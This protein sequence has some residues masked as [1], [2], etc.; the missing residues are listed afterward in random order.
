MKLTADKKNINK[1]LAVI[2][3]GA[4]QVIPGVLN[5]AVSV[6]VVRLFSAAWWGEIIE[7]Q[8]VYYI[9]GSVVSWGNKEYFLREFSKGPARINEL[10]GKGFSTRALYLLLPCCIV[11]FFL[12]KPFIFFNLFIWVSS[13]FIVQSYE[14]VSTYEKKFMPLVA[15][16]V[17]AFLVMILAFIL[18][19]ETLTY[20]NLVLVFS[21]G[22]LVKVPVVFFSFRNYSLFGKTDVK[23]LK[24]ASLFFVLAFTGFVSTKID[25]AIVDMLMPKEDLGF[26]QVITNFFIL[27]R[28][29]S[30]FIL[31]PFVKNIYRFSVAAIEKSARHLLMAGLGICIAGLAAQFVFIKIFY[32]FEVPLLW[33]LY[34]FVYTLPGFWFSPFVFYFFGE[35]KQHLVIYGN[36]LCMIANAALCFALIPA[37]GISGALIAIA[38]PQ[39]MLMLYFRYW[40]R[41]VS[42][43]VS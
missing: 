2:S 33:Y 42:A 6:L 26:Y 34:G 3:N 30:S 35:H 24:E 8:L 9:V 39:I 40:F 11:L 22:Y 10:F 14:S 19:P 43:G 1:L 31:Y 7:L 21:L 15:A 37:Y 13:R 17:A 28:T 32:L 29:V 36:V 12:Y 4:S 27:I 25:L 20:N 16:E 18:W 38:A 5:L 23:L 41:R